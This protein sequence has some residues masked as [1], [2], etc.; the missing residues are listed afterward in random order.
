MPAVRR[1]P[2]TVAALLLGAT[3]G[4]AEFEERTTTGDW[5]LSLGA[6]P[7]PEV[8]ERT[9]GS[10]GASTYEWEQLEGDFAPRLAVGYLALRLRDV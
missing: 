4:A 8:E 9:S 2:A 10:G 1:H 6:A 5:Y 3:L 7:V